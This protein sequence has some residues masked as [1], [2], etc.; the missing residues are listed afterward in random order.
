MRLE[1]VTLQC[2]VYIMVHPEI[3]MTAREYRRYVDDDFDTLGAIDR[4]G[5]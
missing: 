4:Y 1:L 5:A 3:V 2:R